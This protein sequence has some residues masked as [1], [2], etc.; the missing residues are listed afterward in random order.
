VTEKRAPVRD[1]QE[2]MKYPRIANM[3]LR[4]LDEPLSEVFV[5][6]LY[7]PNEKKAG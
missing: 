4:G 5:P 3:G 6:R 7:N 2:M 1:I